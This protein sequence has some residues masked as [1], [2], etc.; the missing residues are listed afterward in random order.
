MLRIYMD[1]WVLVVFLV[2]SFIAG[3]MVAKIRHR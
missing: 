3:F 1:A 2:A